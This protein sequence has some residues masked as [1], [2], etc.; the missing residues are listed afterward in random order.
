MP[1]YLTRTTGT[2]TALVMYCSLNNPVPT[3]RAPNKKRSATQPTSVSVP[4]VGGVTG[5]VGI[6]CS[7]GRSTGGDTSGPGVCE[8]E[9]NGARVGSAIG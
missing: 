9:G 3:A 4:A 8:G 5:G 1:R 6:G 7:E 2:S